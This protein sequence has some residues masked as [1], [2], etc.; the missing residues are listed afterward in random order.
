MSEATHPAWEKFVVSAIN[1]IGAIGWIVF[2]AVTFGQVIARYIFEVPFQ[3][4]EELAR[5][6]LVWFSFLYSVQLTVLDEHIDIGSPSPTGLIG[7]IC[8]YLKYLCI[9]AT[10]LMLVIGTWHIFPV[11]RTSILPATG[12]PMTSFYLAGT[13]AGLGF[14]VFSSLRLLARMADGGRLRLSRS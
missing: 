13:V 5:F 12:L 9:L 1:A 2:I 8:F 7:Q 14:V 6:S 11:V 3:W 10:G 4:A